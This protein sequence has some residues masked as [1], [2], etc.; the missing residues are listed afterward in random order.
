MSFRVL[1]VFKER[2]EW[3]VKTCNAE[4]LMLPVVSPDAIYQEAR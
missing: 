4:N 1:I 2:S 3:V